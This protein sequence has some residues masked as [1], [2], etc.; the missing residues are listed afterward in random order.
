MVNEV[1]VL[2]VGSLHT[3]W[4][5]IDLLERGWDGGRRKSTGVTTESQ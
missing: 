3:Q 1:L 2:D 5:L 4:I